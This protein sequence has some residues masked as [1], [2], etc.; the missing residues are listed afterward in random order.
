MTSYLPQTSTF[1]LVVMQ[2]VTLNYLVAKDWKTL[3]CNFRMS[4]MRK[5]NEQ[6]PV[7]KD[8]KHCCSH[9]PKNRQMD[10]LTSRLFRGE[11]REHNSAK[12]LQSKTFILSKLESINSLLL[13]SHLKKKKK[14]Y[15]NT[16][17]HKL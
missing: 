17:K 6:A 12:K 2:L 15:N 5:L 11:I 13:Y 14:T 8:H 16:P 3:P 7:T 4:V 10:L 9:P 1:P